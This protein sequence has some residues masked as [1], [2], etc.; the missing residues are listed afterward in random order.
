MSMSILLL[1]LAFPWFTMS[2]WLWVL[3]YHMSNITCAKIAIKVRDYNSVHSYRLYKTNIRLTPWID[4]MTHVGSCR[5]ITIAIT[6]CFTYLI[7]LTFLW[8]SKPKKF[9]LELFSWNTASN[10]A[11]IE[12]FYLA[13][14]GCGFPWKYLQVNFFEPIKIVIKTNSGNF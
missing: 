3:L 1:C 8:W 2:Q 12:V 9:T 11:R 6:E 5:I 7:W 4:I 13:G 10:K 14:M